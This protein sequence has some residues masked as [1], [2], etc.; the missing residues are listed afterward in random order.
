MNSED[1]YQ[2]AIIEHAKQPKNHGKLKT[3][4]ADAEGV[5]P[6]CGDSIHLYLQVK[7]NIIQAI[8]FENAGCAISTAAASLMT[9]AILGK[10]VE[11]AHALWDGFRTLVTEG[12]APPSPLLGKLAVFKGVGAYPARVKCATLAWHA[13]QDGLLKE[14]VIRTLKTIFDPEIP[15]NI[16]DLGLIYGLTVNAQ[17]KTVQIQMTLTTPACPVAQ[18]FPGTVEQAVAALAGVA[19]A[20]VELVWDPPWSVDQL[21]EAA[22]LELGL[23]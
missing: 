4:H 3:F 16:Y 18:S 17:R 19:I 20:K 1:L 11:E 14:R 6:L 9:E 13:L 12:A 8:S 5:N 15:V 22:R 23:L 21:S 7:D 2:L 10:T